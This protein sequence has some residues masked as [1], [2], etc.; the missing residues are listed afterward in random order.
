MEDERTFFKWNNDPRPKCVFDNPTTWQREIWHGGKLVAWCAA[1]LVIGQAPI[2]GEFYG[3]IGWSPGE[4]LSGDHRAM[5]EELKNGEPCNHPGC[6]SHITHPC[7]GCGRIG[8]RGRT[9]AQKYFNLKMVVKQMRDHQNA[10]PSLEEPFHIWSNK[11][12]ELK[13][14][15]DKELEK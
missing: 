11:M 3:E 1:R 5:K 4:I 10:G 7:E 6:Q 9:T 2:H 15:V 14:L 13:K 8:A 12:K